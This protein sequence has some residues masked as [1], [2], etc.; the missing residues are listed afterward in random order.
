MVGRRTAFRVLTNTGGYSAF[1]SGRGKSA[2]ILAEPLRLLA[3]V[4][5]DADS[6]AAPPPPPMAPSAAARAAAAVVLPTSSYNS[7][8]AAPQEPVAG[9]YSAFASGRDKSGSTSAESL[10]QTA[11]V[12][13]GADDG[14]APPPLFTA[15]SAAAGAAAVASNS[16]KP[17]PAVSAQ[18]AT[19][20]Y[21]AFATGRGQIWIDLG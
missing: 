14:V 6:E 3:P 19:G 5:D 9:G 4:Y 13:D 12:Y 20:G 15:P 18:S 10:G 2:A 8:S 1:A 7:H 16:F 21:S 17:P 11:R